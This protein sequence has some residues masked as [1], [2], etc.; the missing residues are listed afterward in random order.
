M[1]VG[2]YPPPIGGVAIH[3]QRLIAGC[4]DSGIECTVV[5]V[6]RRLK[7]VAGV[8]NIIRI[9]DWPRILFSRQEIVHIHTTDVHWK[10]PAVFFC[11]ARLKGAPVV[12]SYHS[13]RDTFEFSSIG[14]RVMRRILKS[15][16]RIIAISLEIKNKLVSLG[17]GSDNI[18]VIP[19]FLPPV[20]KGEEIH[21][22]PAELWTFM[23]SHRPVIAANA[24]DII[25]Y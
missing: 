23:E 4:R 13:L 12:L 15:T 11:L 9:T 24:Y 7:K 2:V 16:S 17:A 10:L 18:S 6:S 5:D 19:A 1:Q 8:L 20:M 21:A 25:K 22:C 3:I 14:R